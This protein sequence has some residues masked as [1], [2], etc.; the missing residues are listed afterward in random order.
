MFPSV[1]KSFKVHKSH[2]FYTK[3]LQR[4]YNKISSRKLLQRMVGNQLCQTN[5]HEKSCS[6]QPKKTTSKTSQTIW[7]RTHFQQ[8]CQRTPH[9][10]THPHTHHHTITQLSWAMVYYQ[11]SVWRILNANL[12]IC[13]QQR[14]TNINLLY[15]AVCVTVILVDVCTWCFPGMRCSQLVNVRECECA[16]VR[17]CI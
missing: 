10:H 3:P 13:P 7:S 8:T 12:W 6:E 17:L 16:C 4:G 15:E 9:T 1:Q 5:S 11:S 2:E 14:T